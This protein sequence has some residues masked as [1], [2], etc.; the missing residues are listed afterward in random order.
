MFYV[1]QVLA[2]TEHQVE[3][4]C[5][6]MIHEGEEVFIPLINMRK[7]VRG[8]DEQVQRPMFPG[9][10]FFDTTEVEDL[11]F[12][13][14]KIKTLTKILKTDDEFTPLNQEEEDMIRRLGGDKH[15]VD[16][17][18]GYKEGDRV[19]ITEG[20]LTGLESQIKTINRTR[21]TAALLVPLMGEIREVTMGLVVLNKET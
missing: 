5:N 2:G 12:R 21:R 8:V 17:S 11:F 20:P 15:I 6:K 10:V 1:I 13:L 3:F 18:I 16:I 14:K 9:Y 19:T 4:Q 7:R